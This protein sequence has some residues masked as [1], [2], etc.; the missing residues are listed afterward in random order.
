MLHLLGVCN[1]CLKVQDTI[2]SPVIRQ[3]GC[4]PFFPVCHVPG[5]ALGVGFLRECVTTIVLTSVLQS[6]LPQPWVCLHVNSSACWR[7]GPWSVWGIC[8]AQGPQG[9]VLGRTPE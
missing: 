1:C 5:L 3:L 7:R 4:F 6:A 8:G 9:G 2:Q